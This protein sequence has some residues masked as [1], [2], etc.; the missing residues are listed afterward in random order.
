MIPV[1]KPRSRRLTV[2][3]QDP[4][5]RVDG[6]VLTTEVEIPAEEIAPGPR[7]YRVQVVDYDTSGGVLYQPMEYPQ[8]QNGQYGDPFKEDAQRPTNESLIADPRFHQQNVY[9]IVMKTLAR[10]EFALGRRIGWSFPGHQI[11]VA[12]HAFADANAFYSKRDQALVFGYFKGLS[13]QVVFSCLSHDVVAHETTHAILDGL[14]NRY[15]DPSSPEQAGFH[16]GF[17]DVV[18]LLSV[19]SL[20]EVVAT[21][22]QSGFD[23]ER[24]R[25]DLISPEELTIEKLRDSVLLGLAKQMGQ[26]MEGVRGNRAHALRRSVKL[27]PLTD[28]DDP[29]TYAKLEEFQEP[30][31]RGEI[32]VAAMLN[33]FLQVWRTRITQL[34][35]GRPGAGLDLQMVVEQGTDSAN[36][37]LTMAIRALD[38][39]PPTD[40]QFRD[41]LSALITADKE[42]VPDD[43]KYEYR[44]TLLKSFRDYGIKPASF[45]SAD[46]S[47]EACNAQLT[48]DR[49]HFESLLRD[50]DEVFRFI[51]ENRQALKLEEHAYTKVTSVRPCLRIAPDGF[52]LR[53]TVAEYIQM[54]TLQAQE[55]Q[56]FDPPIG[57]PEGM[58]PD[59]EVTLYGGGALIFDEYGRLKYQVFNRINNASLQTPRLK[60]LWKYGYFADKDDEQSVFARLHLN[61]ALNLTTDASE[62]F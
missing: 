41:Y 32:L 59:E 51:W 39:A 61:R 48:Y 29:K 4:S 37:L 38:Y 8:L 6:R 20:T 31:R 44:K 53:E 21:L 12:P 15:T 25:S 62:R 58:S 28:K 56:V 13:G 10:F 1:A 26:E 54:V 22:L 45:N 17:A 18:A 2:I 14:R 24:N 7:G 19:F 52:A 5:I 46:G 43:S 33:A 50:P 36:Q 23:K 3:A 35:R 49:S 40:L 27:R 16:E 47:W 30:H 42:L 60:Y 9:A 57:K 34:E 55:L 11:N